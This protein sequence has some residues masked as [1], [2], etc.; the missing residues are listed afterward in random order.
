M[1]R[2]GSAI[3]TKYPDIAD[4]GSGRMRR[5]ARTTRHPELRYEDM[6]PYIRTRVDRLWEYYLVYCTLGKSMDS[7]AFAA[8]VENQGR[9]QVS[10]QS[11]L[12]SP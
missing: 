4:L 5:R 7:K 10:Q 3:A 12:N 9:R 1:Y 8:W 6:S 11:R 2:Y